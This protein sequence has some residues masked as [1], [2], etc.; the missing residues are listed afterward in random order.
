MFKWLSRL[1]RLT[2][3]GVETG[4]TAA[5]DASGDEDLRRAIHRTIR[6][7]TADFDAFKYNTALAKLMALTNEVSAAVR[8]RGARGGE[9]QHALEA[10]SIMLS[11][12]A[13]HV[14]EEIWHRL[15]HDDFVAAQRW[16]EF[17]A[18]L[19]VEQ[20]LQVPV[21]VD[22]RV[23]DTI[24]VPAGAAQDDVVERA[25]ASDNVRRHLSERAIAK[26][27]WVPD[28]LLNIVTRPAA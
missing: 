15:G 22:G 26:V 2:D 24:T 3:E 19:L 21:Q 18:A 17:D 11:P 12:L 4:G 1:V 10:I 6:D 25:R 28:R 13:P 20:T 16:P 5:A 7:V 9:P 23:R 8:E 14:S 27:I